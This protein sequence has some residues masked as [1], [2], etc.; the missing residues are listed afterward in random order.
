MADNSEVITG[1][2]TITASTRVDVATPIINL[3][4]SA[5]I[6]S[7]GTGATGTVLKDLK[8]LTASSLSGTKLLVAIDVAW[9]PYYFEVYP[10]KE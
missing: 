9:T 7:K 4:A 6:A 5:V 1:M 2:K 8:T 3:D 10:T